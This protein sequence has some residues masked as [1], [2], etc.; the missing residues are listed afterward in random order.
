VRVWRPTSPWSSPAL[1][2]KA[3]KTTNHHAGTRTLV[4]SNVPLFGRAYL[5]VGV[6]A[7]VRSCGLKSALRGGAWWNPVEF[8]VAPPNVAHGLECV[9][10]AAAFESPGVSGRWHASKAAASCTHSRRFATFGCATPNSTDW[11]PAG[12]LRYDPAT[13]GPCGKRPHH[14]S[15]P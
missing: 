6:R 2:P 11:N 15:A 7:R 13:D 8:G 10:L 3:T 5:F 14:W 4:R 9:Q 12:I 1:A